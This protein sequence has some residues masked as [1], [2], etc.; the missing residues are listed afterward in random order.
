ML[1]IF[2]FLFFIGCDH[3]SQHLINDDPQVIQAREAEPF[4]VVDDNISLPDFCNK[5]I[6]LSISN[7]TSVISAIIKLAKAHNLNLIINNELLDSNSISYNATQKKIIDI[8]S[9]LCDLCNWKLTVN[10]HSVKIEPDNSYIF[11]HKLNILNTQAS[12]AVL[13]GVNDYYKAEKVVN[14]GSSAKLK[15]QSKNHIWQEIEEYLKFLVRTKQIAINI[16]VDNTAQ[17][18]NKQKKE[19]EKQ[20]ALEEKKAKALQDMQIKQLAIQQQVFLKDRFINMQN[21]DDEDTLENLDPTKNPALQEEQNGEKAEENEN[22][23]T[24]DSANMN[25]MNLNNNDSISYS[26]NKQAGFIVLKAPQKI[27]RELAKYIHQLE[28]KMTS[29]IKLEARIIQIDLQDEYNMG[30]N[31]SSLAGG[32]DN[33]IEIDT[34]SG[35]G[36]FMKFALGTSGNQIQGFIQALQKYGNTH[37]ISKPELTILNNENGLFKVVENFVY[38]KIKASNVSFGH[39]GTY[40]TYNSDA[41]VLPVGFSMVMQPSI[42]P[43]TGDILL[44]IRPTITAVSRTVE[45]PII[46]LNADKRNIIKSEYPVIVSR[47][48]DTKLRLKAGQWALL[49]GHITNRKERT[50]KGLP[51]VQTPLGALFG[52]KSGKDR[53]SEIVCILRAFPQKCSIKTLEQRLLALLVQP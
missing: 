36:N 1:F 23:N 7:G 26:I 19:E 4:V 33:S 16:P 8:L 11:M 24:D 2:L 53:N 25:Y 6:N 39:S 31:W 40:Y 30:I 46:S 42:D 49:G 12:T 44:H 43:D 14:I 50:D 41:Q 13:T 29:Q 21:N 27:H 32:K 37:T 22:N 20:K 10:D 38:F 47:E 18:T 52:S 3:K 45:D 48:F 17:N 9:E 34:S 51:G 15:T 28:K 5:K 35:N